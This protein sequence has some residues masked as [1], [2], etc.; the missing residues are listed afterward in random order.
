VRDR[1]WADEAWQTACAEH[2]SLAQDSDYAAG[3]KDGF[4][5]HVWRGGNGEPPPL[6][7]LKYRALRYQTPAGYQAIESWF[8]GYRQGAFAAAHG[9]YRD[10]VTGPSSLRNAPAPTGGEPPI[11]AAPAPPLAAPAPP[12]EAIPHR[13]VP[14]WLPP[15]PPTPELPAPRRVGAGAVRGPD[16]APADLAR[17]WDWL[18]PRS[19]PPAW[20]PTVPQGPAH[21]EP[22]GRQSGVR[23]VGDAVES[24]APPGI[25]VLD[26]ADEGK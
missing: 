9:G 16:P 1:R 7:P 2:P 22:S 6:P 20:A 24:G 26:Q 10:L 21:A 8:N 5:E 23:L 19:G 25:R 14:G 15:T 4:V 11:A 18:N 17:R 3:F 12:L 13:A